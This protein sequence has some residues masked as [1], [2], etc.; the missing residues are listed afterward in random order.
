[1][2]IFEANQD[3]VT[4]LLDQLDVSKSHGPDNRPTKLLKSLS[5]EISPCLT[6]I[7]AA[8]LHPG[9]VPQG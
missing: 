2:P 3:G 1:M 5:T 4:H 9:T 8:S 7:F 6:L